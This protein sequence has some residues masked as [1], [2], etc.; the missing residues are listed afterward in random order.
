MAVISAILTWLG[1]PSAGAV[2]AAN[3]PPPSQWE[4]LRSDDLRVATV[5]Y[6]LSLANAALCRGDAVPQIGFVL[7]SIEQYSPEDRGAVA[8]SFG[9]GTL[10]GV[11]A[12][13][14]GSPAAHAGLAAGDQL[15]SVNGRD[16]RPFQAGTGAPTNAGVTATRQILVTE[17]TKG[18]VTIRVNGP[19]GDRDIQ[20]TAAAGCPANIELI[21]GAAVNAWADGHTVVVS[22]GLLSRCDHDDDLALVI[23][24]ELSHNLL[25]HAERL[26]R[27]D[28]AKSG[29]LR[30]AGPGS[31]EMRE[32]EEEAD[33]LGAHLA[34]AAGYDLRGAEPFLRGLLASVGPDRPATTHPATARRLE[35][36]TADIADANAGQAV[37]V[38]R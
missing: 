2:A 33:R 7:Q 15:V 4:A 1:V 35:L 22:A 37:S 23:A 30:T 29:L 24:H 38:P 8:R 34:I 20:F 3:S 28:A 9:L 11:I 21:P 17:M 5:A 26:A 18:A 14:P 25:H 12:V 10:V 13:V 16:L 27:A 31:A 6:R 32:T 36:L 19:R